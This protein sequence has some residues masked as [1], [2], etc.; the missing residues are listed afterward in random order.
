VAD[1]DVTAVKIP[2]GTSPSEDA[3][4]GYKDD[5]TPYKVDPARYRKRDAKRRG[6]TSK[7]KAATSKRKG[8]PYKQDVLGLIQL[9]AAPVFVIGMRDDTFAA[10]A[11]AIDMHAEPIADACAQIAE[12]NERFARAL[13]KLAEVGPYG[14]LIAAVAPL[15]FQ[16]AANHGLV[17]VGLMG[18]KDPNDLATVL[19]GDV[20][21]MQ[22]DM[23]ADF[24]G[25]ADPTEPQAYTPGNAYGPGGVSYGQQGVG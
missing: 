10:D 11:V 24:P 17:P 2:N 7:S 13:D 22:A 15:A 3:P 18:A 23:T 25:P 8:S 1:D 12:K 20:E 19:R 6:S 9:V 21:R 5:G 14:A 16:V 4:W